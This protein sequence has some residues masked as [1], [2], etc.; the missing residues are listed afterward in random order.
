MDRVSNLPEEVRCHI[1]SF[2]PTKH[3]V[4]TSV[5]SKS[6]L[7]LWKFETNLVIDDSDFLH[8]EEG[9]GE[10][11]EIRQSFVEFVDGILALQA[12]S[13]IEKFSLKC[14]TG[15]HP[16]HV[17]RWICNVLQRGVSD[18]YLFTDFS[19]EDT[20]EDDYRL[21][22]QLFVSK[23]LVK[24]KLRSEHCVNW[25]WHW[26][27]GASLPMLKSLNID[28]D[29]I[30]CGAME[31]F[32]HSFPV[33]E[34]IHMANMEWRESDES[35]T[36]SSAS[37]RK[38][39][40]HG[41]GVEEF[42][43]PKSIS[44][45]TPSLLYLNYS[46]LVAEDYPLVKMGKL[47]Q[48][49]INLIVKNEDQIKRIREP[50]NDL[51]EDDEGDVVLQFGNVVKLMNGIQN[52]QKLYLTADTLEVL[53]KCCESMPVFNNLKILGLKSDEG[54]GWQAVPSILRNCPHL[55]FLI[56]EGLLHYV[57]EKCGDACVCISREDKGRSLISCPVKKLQVSGFRGTIREKE[58][59]RHFLEYFPCVDEMEIDAEED[60]STN[61]E[62]PRILKI[63]A[64]KLYD[65]VSTEIVGH[66]KSSAQSGGWSQTQ[67]DEMYSEFAPRNKERIYDM[68]FM[69]RRAS[70]PV[71]PPLPQEMSQDYLQMQLEAADL[72]ER[73][74]DQ[75]AQLADLKERQRAMFDMIVDQNPMIASALRARE[76]TDSE[77]A[78]GSSGQEMTEKKRD[79]DALFDIIAEQNP[80]LASALRALRATDTE[81]AETSRDQEMTKLGQARAADFLP[82]D[83]E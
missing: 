11:D 31:D 20:E 74:R 64:Y 65:V 35:E 49:R 6:W 68:V 48:A 33:L 50:N 61:F 5:L 15:V 8:P 70:S 76:A 25:W 24:L 4:L 3:A 23:T 60:D 21:P 62:V 51:L 53:T 13:P 1:L 77:R 26:E 12:D 82:R 58:M 39:S 30:F 28:S 42:E 38:L 47:F 10:R 40:I 63:V 16:D 67:M 56:I 75:E 29:L 22:L 80:M 41:T 71:P 27:M 57:T 44:F 73:L 9:K 19:D 7:N 2:L 14:I 18:L 45:D 66:W 17:N 37:L 34:E 81:R 36:M 52:I 78:K 54:R 32:L 55:E 59:I 79:Y 46:D 72:K 69:M 83:G 43:N